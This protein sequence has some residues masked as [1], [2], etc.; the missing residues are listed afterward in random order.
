M[1]LTQSPNWET[2]SALQALLLR[3]QLIPGFPFTEGI[4]RENQLEGRFEVIFRDGERCDARLDLSTQ[5]R[6]EG[7][8]W[9]TSHGIFPKTVVACWRVKPAPT[10][11]PSNPS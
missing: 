2:R 11:P 4:P 5:Y 1:S 9:R 7:I 6:A 10:P 3:G 8:Q